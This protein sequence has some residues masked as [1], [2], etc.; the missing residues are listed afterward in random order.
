MLMLRLAGITVVTCGLLAGTVGTGVAHAP[1]PIGPN[2]H[3]VGLV[4]GRHTDAVIY[5]VCP[6]PATG[7]GPVAGGQTVGVKRVAS[8]GG[9][10]GSAAHAIY[11][12]VTPT[13]IVTL[14]AYA[15]PVRIPTSAQVPCQGTGIVT[16]SASPLPQ[17]RAAGAEVDNVPVTYIDISA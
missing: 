16:F 10:T 14:T 17:S 3:F 13:T 4:D 5:T 8:G 9:D 15:H 1:T 6:G 2:Q 7:Y 11:A 12:R